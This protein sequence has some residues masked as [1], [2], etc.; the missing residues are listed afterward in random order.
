MDN[1]SED[2]YTVTQDS[3]TTSFLS[4]ESH[5]VPKLT[6]VSILWAFLTALISLI[7]FFGNLL[8][9][10]AFSTDKK[11][12]TFGNYFIL[13][14]SL[15]DFTVSVLMATWSP[16][17]LTGV[18]RRGTVQ[19]K[20]WLIFDYMVTEASSWNLALISAD[21]FVCVSFPFIYKIKQSPQLAMSLMI[22]P[23]ILGFLTYGIAIIF[24]EA[25]VGIETVP[26]GICDVPFYGDINFLLFGTIMDFYLPFSIVVL[27]SLLLFLNLK[28]RSTSLAKTRNHNTEQHNQYLENTL[29]KDKK[30]ARSLVILVLVYC[31]TWLP[32]EISAVINSVCE[33]CIPG[34][35]F[36]LVFW[37]LWLNSA[38]NPLVYA[39]LQGKFRVAFINILCYPF[40]CWTSRV[41]PFAD[42]TYTTRHY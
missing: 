39:Y 23:W 14:L 37:M 16:F 34:P 36:S 41:T 27:F 22:I 8:V 19:C 2:M 3:N 1:L 28:R 5:K 30:I 25:W 21:R 11:I 6:G 10:I 24:W 29:R 4:N 13:N 31:I 35:L 42:T 20:L 18:W 38:V 17:E 33:L 7:T 9:I 32:Y 40:K 15:T 12:R 26:E